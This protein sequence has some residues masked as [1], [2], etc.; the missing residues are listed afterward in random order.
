MLQAVIRLYQQFMDFLK[1]MKEN[2]TSSFAAGAAF[3]VFLSIIPIVL[4]VCSILPLT[5]ISQD[6]LAAVIQGLIPAEVAIFFDS[7]I[8]EFSGQSAT[9]ISIATIITLWTAGKGLFALINGLNAV[10]R[11]TEMRNFLILR[12]RASFYTFLM[13]I[14]MVFSLIVLVFGNL[15]NSL[16]TKF[17]PNFNILLQMVLHF[18]FLFVWAFFTLFF[19]VLYTMLPSKPMIFKEQFPGALFA[20]VGWSVFSW[21][22]SRYM[23]Y[24][25]SFSI[26]GSLTTIIIG[27][28][29]LYFCMYILL[30]GAQI[31]I[32][33][34][35]LFHAI[36]KAQQKKKHA[37][38]IRKKKITMRNAVKKCASRPEGF[39]LYGN[40]RGI[41]CKAKKAG[42]KRPA[43][44]KKTERRTLKIK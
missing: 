28:I 27:M 16:L 33:F 37:K 34:Q 41:S 43:P 1:T 2:N 15:L 5:N 31:N 44:N 40:S 21:G 30:T 39:W 17:I 10:N 29:W 36:N 6:M 11:V 38:K 3:F 32:Y 12:I 24:F 25:N 42:A 9:V 4:L 18:R 13:I 8:L 35:P 19:Q 7:V 22:F 23:D 26:Y 14:V 20:S